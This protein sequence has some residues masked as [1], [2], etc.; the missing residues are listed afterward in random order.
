MPEDRR[1]GVEIEFNALPV[2]A[3]AN[4][5]R[6]HGYEVDGEGDN[7]KEGSTAPWRVV[8]EGSVEYGAELNTPI[9]SRNDPHSWQVIKD[10]MTLI[11]ADGRASVA[12]NAGIHV[13]VEVTDLSAASMLA[14]F[15]L[16]DHYSAGWQALV[17][18]HRGLHIY[19]D[20]EEDHFNNHMSQQLQDFLITRQHPGYEHLEQY[21]NGM[22]RRDNYMP[23]GFGIQCDSYLRQGTLEFRMHH[24][25]LSGERICDWAAFILDYVDYCYYNPH[26][27]PHD[28]GDTW[29]LLNVVSDSQLRRSLFYYPQPQH[30]A[31]F[32]DP[33][34]CDDDHDEYNEYDEVEEIF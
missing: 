8:C 1:F 33:E 9:L 18:Q 19:R 30:A 25:T 23:G 20:H 15:R 13:H 17:G 31:E 7:Y 24:G 3:T 26:H 28:D 21:C 12:S 6:E 34:F 27:I 16:L 22:Y 32:I 14:I 29:S 2:N 5:L 4:L 10:V 11:Q